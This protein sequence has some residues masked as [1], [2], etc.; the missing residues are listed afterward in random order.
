[1]ER[2]KRI[3]LWAV[4]LWG[5][6]C[7]MPV[8]AAEEAEK[9]TEVRQAGEYR[10]R[11]V[12]E[13]DDKKRRLVSSTLFY[14]GQALPAGKPG[15]IRFTPL[16]RFV[17]LGTS[18]AAFP[19][20]DRGVFLDLRRRQVVK[21]ANSTAGRLY[22]QWSVRRRGDTGTAVKTSRAAASGEVVDL[23]LPEG[24]KTGAFAVSLVS[25]GLAKS[26]TRMWYRL[27]PPE[28]Q[29]EPST[30]PSLCRK[31][32]P[33]CFSLNRSVF[34]LPNT[35]PLVQVLRVRCRNLTEDPVTIPPLAVRADGRSRLS[36]FLDLTLE[37][38]RM[39]VPRGA[40]NSRMVT[41]GPKESY[42]VVLPLAEL[43]PRRRRG[44]VVRCAVRPL[45]YWRGTEGRQRFR[46]TNGVD[47][48]ARFRVGGGPDTLLYRHPAYVWERARDLLADKSP[49][50]WVDDFGLGNKDGAYVRPRSAPAPAAPSSRAFTRRY[51]HLGLEAVFYAP[52]GD[53]PMFLKR[54]RK[55]LDILDRKA[56][57]VRLE[58]KA[59]EQMSR[60]SAAVRLTLV[61]RAGF[62]QV[63]VFWA[64]AP[65]RRLRDPR[66]ERTVYLLSDELDIK[67]SH[68]GSPVP[69]RSA[70]VPVR[71]AGLYNG[72][73]E[74]SA[75][76]LPLHDLFT[77]DKKGR[78][79][80]RVRYT[81][82]PV[83][84]EDARWTVPGGDAR[85]SFSLSE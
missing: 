7:F 59:A 55:A 72:Y 57:P 21:A 56:D 75:V 17:A 34:V 18:W 14:R 41:L 6:L 71:Q 25:G 49:R 79:T 52:R 61:R 11:R 84:K 3:F 44:G 70:V 38:E 30:T 58:L 15:R 22:L 50:A 39:P 36:V 42:T 4:S 8:F 2:V 73:R 24:K 78:Y 26:V 46:R 53:V 9:Q 66:R 85:L 67:L 28:R 32:P 43:F 31:A 47:L 12:T 65:V 45:P 81:P 62:D 33:L 68:N 64:A 63:P 40:V 5:G 10:Y 74:P 77:L 83:T 60:R 29:T 51:P 23:P 13:V 54:C 20:V 19:E 76:E 27:P 80:L 16:G 48:A 82:R 1:M 35:G 37:R 69:R